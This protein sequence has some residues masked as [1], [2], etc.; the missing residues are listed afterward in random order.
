M[1]GL[2]LNEKSEMVLLEMYR[3]RPIRMF[4]LATGQ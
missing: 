2:E 4:L 3:I 1:R